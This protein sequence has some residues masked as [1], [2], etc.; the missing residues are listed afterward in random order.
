MLPHQQA[1]GP[2]ASLLTV[3][4]QEELLLRE[5]SQVSRRGA[6]VPKMRA[7]VGLAARAAGRL[8]LRRPTRPTPKSSARRSASM[9]SRRRREKFADV[10]HEHPR[11]N[12][13][14][15]LLWNCFSAGDAI[16]G[17]LQIPTFPPRLRLSAVGL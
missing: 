9:C 15:L 11:R 7:A 12:F 17:I 4:A 13:P 1:E 16:Q 6:A 5:A 3:P 2:K 10:A 14:S 8:R